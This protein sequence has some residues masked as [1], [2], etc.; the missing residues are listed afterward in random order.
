MKRA[1]LSLYLLAGAIIPVLAATPP[2]Y[3][4]EMSRTVADTT[5]WTNPAPS[6]FY[7]RGNYHF[8]ASSSV[9]KASACPEGVVVY[10]TGTVQAKDLRAVR[11]HGDGSDITGIIGGAN[12][13]LESDVNVSTN[14]ERAARIATDALI[15]AATAQERVERVGADGVLTNAVVQEQLD[16]KA[17]DV[18]I[19]SATG[20]EQAARVATDNLI[21]KAT[22]QEL[23]DRLAADTLIGQTT[24]Y[25][26]AARINQDILIGKATGYEQ[27]VR[28][29]ADTLLG[30]ATTAQGVQIANLGQST[31]SWQASLVSEISS[32]TAAD[33]LTGRATGQI[34]L[35]VV[36]LAKSTGIVA[37]MAGAAQGDL[38]YNN[39][40]S[41]AK[42]A[43]G[44]AGQVLHVA[45]L[46]PAWSAPDDGKVSAST[47]IAAGYLTSGVIISTDNFPTSGGPGIYTYWRGDGTWSIPNA[48]NLADIR[49]GTTTVAVQVAANKVEIDAL[50]YA[51]STEITVRYAQDVLIGQATGYLFT[52]VGADF[53]C[54]KSTGDLMRS[55]AEVKASTGSV[56]GY[57]TTSSATTNYIQYA[58]YNATMTV[59]TGYV[60]R[61]AMSTYT[62][63]VIDTQGTT[64]QTFQK[65]SSSASWGTASSGGSTV[66]QDVTIPARAWTADAFRDTACLISVQY[67]KTWDNGLS[68]TTLNLLQFQDVPKPV[69]AYAEFT[70]PRGWLA[71]NTNVYVNCVTSCTTLG[72]SGQKYISGMTLGVSTSPFNV[73]TNYSASQTIVACGVTGGSDLTGT[74]PA[75]D[76][77][78]V[79]TYVVT[80]LVAGQ[81][82]T[83][84]LGR[85]PD[86]P[87]VQDIYVRSVDI[88]KN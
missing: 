21:G 72:G 40:T 17:A 27:A 70:V 31:A 64:G 14:A 28:Q 4:N 57:L 3:L 41:W 66:Y 15:S 16:R 23:V 75:F 39:G 38:W 83:L 80:G 63:S 35:S 81:D 54:R 84:H 78:F 6:D 47:G 62:L 61:V 65:F 33:Q 48:Q 56:S 51:T 44:S 45:G 67:E 58:Q 20:Y 19:G 77:V 25:E 37:G 8:V 86:D 2:Y 5:T 74:M 46:V 87:C 69:F 79:A 12:F 68:S 43:R 60:N 34:V 52:Q 53:E 1:I 59:A 85:Q 82:V 71:T 55:I 88:G 18:L 30:G 29:A 22:T 13:A 36:D 42:F 50:H 26:W 10:A 24:G 49:I 76:N 7:Y 73:F 9:V 32:R 11:L